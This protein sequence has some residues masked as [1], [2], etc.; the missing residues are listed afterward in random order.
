MEQN[1]VAKSGV[2]E[3]AASARRRVT[4]VALPAPRDGRPEAN[5][6]AIDTAREAEGADERAKERKEEEENEKKRKLADDE[7][8]MKGSEANMAQLKVDYIDDGMIKE[9][10]Y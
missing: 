6:D 9:R 2:H 7:D 10:D 5:I 8:E 3:Q 1:R 4:Y